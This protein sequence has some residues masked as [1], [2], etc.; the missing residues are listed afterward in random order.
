MELQGLDEIR[1]G[2][3]INACFGWMWFSI[4]MI[5]GVSERTAESLNQSLLDPARSAQGGL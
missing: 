2:C 1:P 4:A 5:R 3:Y